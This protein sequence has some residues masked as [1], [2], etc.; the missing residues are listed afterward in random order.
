MQR[1]HVRW[2]E[3][4][5]TKPADYLIRFFFGGVATAAIGWIAY[6]FGP[7]V[8]GLFLAFPAILPASLTLAARNDG[9]PKAADEARGAVAGSVGLAAFGLVIWLSSPLWS[10]PLV[11][12]VALLA[13]FVVSVVAWRVAL[14]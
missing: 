1:V 4:K 9:R 10:A 5:E 11:L 14:V 3:V 2:I 13:W 8:G 12:V 6:A 7:V